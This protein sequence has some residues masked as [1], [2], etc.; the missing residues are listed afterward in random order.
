[1]KFGI[2]N[3]NCIAMRIEPCSTSEMTSQILF[4]ETFKISKIKGDWIKIVLDFDF[5]EGWVLKNQISALDQVSHS[6]IISNNSVVSNE[7]VT[8]VADQNDNLQIISLG[9]TLPL[10]SS[11]SFHILHQKLATGQSNYWTL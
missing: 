9:A 10:Y 6:E 8:Y 11:N 1:M 7:L 5:Y 2:C 3:L 4:G